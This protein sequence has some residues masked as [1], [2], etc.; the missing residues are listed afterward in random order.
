MRDLED[1]SQRFLLIFKSVVSKF[2]LDLS[3]KKSV[4][5]MD[6]YKTKTGKTLSNFPRSMT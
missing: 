3:F 6:R 2:L 4:V 1:Y 5:M